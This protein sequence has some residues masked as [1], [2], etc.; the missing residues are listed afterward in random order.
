LN[1]KVTVQMLLTQTGAGAAVAAKT[2][3]ATETAMN[4]VTVEISDMNFG[5]RR[6]FFLCMTEMK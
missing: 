6:N 2:C 3:G 1:G 5:Q 4:A